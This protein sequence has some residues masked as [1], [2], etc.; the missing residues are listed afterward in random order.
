MQLLFSILS[1]RYTAFVDLELRST[2]CLKESEM[3]V[4]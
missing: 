1:E 4:W 2:Y 3:V